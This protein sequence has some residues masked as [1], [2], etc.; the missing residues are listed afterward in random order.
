MTTQHIETLVI[1]GG[2][3]GLATAYHLKRLGRECLVVDAGERIGDNWRRH[4]DSLT[5]YS[6]AKYDGLP[7]LPF[8]G[9]KWR[10]PGKEEV[11]DFLER[12]AVHHDLPVRLRTSVDRLTARDGGGFVAHL[13]SATI[14]CDNVVVATGTFGRT[15]NVPAFAGGLSPSIRQWHSTGYR[16]PRQLAPGPTLVV[17]ASHTGCDLAYEIAADRPTIL[18]GPDRGQV[19]LHWDSPLFKVAIPIIVF[20]W[21][22]VLTRRTPMGRKQFAAVRGHGAPMLRVKRQH[23]AERG[24]ERITEKVTGAS[25]DGR[26]V[27]AGGRVLDVANVIW[28]TGFRQDFGWIDLPITGEGGWPDEYRGVTESVPGLFFCGLAFQYAFGS[29]VLP[30]VGR[31]AAYVARHIADRAR[32][33]ADAPAPAR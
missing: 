4:W 28:C 21:L 1:G 29:M 20:A 3:A 13:G 11:A 30:G 6:P 25:P 27:L 15:P 23:L 33:R 12:Y 31:D 14:D 2:Q 19:P 18:A 7:G 32:N 5:L 22:H 17:G 10:F 16:N 8:P 26:P 24:V 9:D